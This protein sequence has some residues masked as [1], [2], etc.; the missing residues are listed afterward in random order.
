M[1]AITTAQRDA[2]AD[3]MARHVG[4]QGGSIDALDAVLA[5]LGITVSDEPE[6]PDDVIERAR[7]T[8]ERSMGRAWTDEGEY[9]NLP[10]QAAHDLATA[11]LLRAAR[12]AR[13]AGE[14]GR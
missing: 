14:V 3:A 9:A 7:A 12:I 10:Q 8:V 5:A 2:A 6:T 1:N 13:E 11:G 4:W